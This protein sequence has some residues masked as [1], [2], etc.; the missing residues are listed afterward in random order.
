[1]NDGQIRQPPSGP[2]LR[3]VALNDV[4]LWNPVTQQWETGPIPG[5]GSSLASGYIRATDGVTTIPTGAAS[6]TWVPIPASGMVEDFAATGWDFLA[7]PAFS[8]TFNPADPLAVQRWLMR[9]CVTMTVA[10][11]PAANEPA[12]VG[13]SL[14]N[15]LSGLVTPTDFNGGPQFGII[16]PGP[17]QGFCVT[18]RMVSVAAGDTLWPVFGYNDGQDLILSRFTVTLTPG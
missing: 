17:T 7:I 5:G 18:E 12:F 6:G 16:E 1:M 15:D 2:F 8:L 14:N 3:G 11:A 13:I 9:V 10:I 4:P